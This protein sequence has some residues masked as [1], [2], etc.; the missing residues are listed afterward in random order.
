VLA[1]EL[2]R[3]LVGAWLTVRIS[4]VRLSVDKITTLAD[5]A[6]LESLKCRGET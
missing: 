3:I 4:F 6:V 5:L 2:I 1:I